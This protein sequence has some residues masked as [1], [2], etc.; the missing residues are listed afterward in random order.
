M[1]PIALPANQPADRFYR[2]GPRI[3]AFREGR[4]FAGETGAEY[5]PEDWVGSTTCVRG[6]D[7]VGQT[8]LPDGTGLAA[9]V[10]RDPTG[11]LGAEHVDAFGADT[12]L[13]VK[14]L[15]AGQRLPVHAHPDGAFA[16]EH[17][18]ARHGKA[19]AWYLLTGGTI[20]LGL[21]RSLTSAELRELVDTQ[22][23]DTLLAA[24]QQVDVRAHDSVFVPPG[25]LHAIGEGILLA[26]VQEPEDLSI[27]LDWRDFHLD[28]AADGHLG[29]G[30]DTALRAV[31]A[32]ARTSADVESLISRAGSGDR[33]ADGRRSYLPPLADRYFGL[34]RIDVV[35]A[36]TV[37]A[38]FSV[39]I[40]LGGDCRITAR[41]GSTTA[42]PGGST[43]LIPHAAGPLDLTGSGRVLVA[44]PPRPARR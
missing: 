2:G 36:A 16:R 5:R 26:E 17:L 41:D 33:A 6:D 10:E 38:G 21:R 12:M 11:W 34:Q 30:F 28:G 3:T 18:G 22:D 20:H 39:M 25:V 31:E 40:G 42:V 15:D 14:L 19:E 4:S 44:R 32:T 24:M 1:R 43:V 27:L 8:M 13:L 9:A 29:L 23:V 35:G 37:E 7:P